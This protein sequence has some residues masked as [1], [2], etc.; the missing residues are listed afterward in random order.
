MEAIRRAVLP[1][2]SN[3]AEP[4]S[5][6]KDRRHYNERKRDTL[7]KLCQKLF[8]KRDMHNGIC[9]WCL[10]DQAQDVTSVQQRALF[11]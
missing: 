9:Q 2:Y 4:E 11:K 8:D 6:H 1:W 3:D 10:Y 5:C 7:C